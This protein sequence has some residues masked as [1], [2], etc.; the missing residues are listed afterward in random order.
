MSD[1]KRI[2]RIGVARLSDLDP[3]TSYLEQDGFEDRLAE[4]Q[5]GN[6][7]FIGIRA[8]ADVV[9]NGV[10]QS[11]YSGGLWGVES[12]S[13]E[14]YLQSIE[15]EEIDSLKSILYD[16][17]FTEQAAETACALQVRKN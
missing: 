13:D 2:V 8:C 17:G 15:A 14:S 1:T 5:R 10:C 12:D 3:D 4:H 9:V 16:L 11:I 7:D 6:F